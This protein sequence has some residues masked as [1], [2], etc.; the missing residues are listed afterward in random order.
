V[1]RQAPIAH[2]YGAQPR[3]SRNAVVGSANGLRSAQHRTGQARPPPT[4]SGGGRTCHNQDIQTR[5]AS[6]AW[7]TVNSPA[8]QCQQAGH[9]ASSAT[10]RALKGPAQIVSAGGTARGGLRRWRIVE[11]RGANDGNSG[12]AARPA[13]RGCCGAPSAPTRRP[14]R[15]WPKNQTARGPP[16][17]ARAPARA[18]CGRDRS[19]QGCLR[20]AWEH[21]VHRG[22]RG[23]ATLGHTQRFRQATS[24]GADAVEVPWQIDAEHAQTF[25]LEQADGGLCAV[26]RGEDQVRVQLDNRL[27]R[28]AHDRKVRCLGGDEG[29]RRVARQGRQ[30]CHLLECQQN[31]HLVGAEVKR[32]NTIR[33]AGGRA[34][35]IHHR[36]NETQ[37]QEQCAARERGQS[38]SVPPCCEVQ[39][40]ARHLTAP[41]PPC[42]FPWQARR[43]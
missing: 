6:R 13:D 2:D 29:Q 12:V 10:A 35:Q 17:V 30:R 25:L 4:S 11:Q 22:D 43:S 31:Q 8:R 15:R 42:C 1:L 9:R 7:E 23:F 41:T 37:R 36:G 3:R 39:P 40:L 14:S 27:G 5:D 16:S 26:R 19:R 28:C 24:L 32:H 33:G 18:R 20:Q 21:R 34:M 38:C